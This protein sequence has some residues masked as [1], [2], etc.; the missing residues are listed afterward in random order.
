MNNLEI[1]AE[2]TPNPNTLKFNVGTS[3]RSP[4][5]PRGSVNFT[6]KS[7][8]GDSLLALRLFEIEEVAGVMIGVD[9]VSVSKKPEA[10]WQMMARDVVETIRYFIQSG[11]PV[12]AKYLEESAVEAS[13]IEKQIRE[14]LDAEIRPAVARDGGDIIFYGYEDGVVKL[15]LQG[16]CSS[17]PSSVLTLKMGIENR[18]KESF[19][20]IKEVIQV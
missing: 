5:L 14:I 8:A 18:L 2:L 12:V 16:A 9:F 15:H 1:S 17:C 3:G 13:P 19:P 4:L 6:D 20:E 10:D 11:E 7:S